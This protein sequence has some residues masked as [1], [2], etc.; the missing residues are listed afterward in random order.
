MIIVV[1]FAI[2]ED[3]SDHFEVVFD[4][5]ELFIIICHYYNGSGFGVDFG[6]S[7]FCSNNL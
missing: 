6:V 3:L 1:I 5:S 2:I 7:T 4:H